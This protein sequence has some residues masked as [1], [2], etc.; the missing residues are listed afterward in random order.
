MFLSVSTIYIDL[1]CQ[2]CQQLKLEAVAESFHVFSSAAFQALASPQDEIAFI[3]MYPW[4]LPLLDA[5][6]CLVALVTLV[7]DA[8]KRDLCPRYLRK[9]MEEEQASIALTATVL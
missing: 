7:V 2:N 5:S 4:M 6:C 9:K 3:A 8:T 1:P